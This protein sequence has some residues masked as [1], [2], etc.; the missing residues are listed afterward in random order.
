MYTVCIL[1]AGEQDK[2]RRTSSNSGVVTFGFFKFLNESNVVGYQAVR[3]EDGGTIH[4]DVSFEGGLTLLRVRFNID[5]IGNKFAIDSILLQD[6]DRFREQFASVLRNGSR[7]ESYFFEMPG[8]SSDEAHMVPFRFVLVNGPELLGRRTNKNAFMEHFAK[9][10]G[11]RVV[12]FSNLSGDARL[13]VPCPTNS[14][15][16]DKHFSHLAAFVRH[17]DKQQVFH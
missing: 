6:D 4:E 3:S 7:F 14:S 12:A 1:L 2:K 10:A 13:V 11:E 8:V 17:A 5:R 16:V 15:S 9:A